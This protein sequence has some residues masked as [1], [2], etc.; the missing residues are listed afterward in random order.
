MVTAYEERAYPVLLSFR[1]RVHLAEGKFCCAEEAIRTDTDWSRRAPRVQDAKLTSE[2]NQNT[3]YAIDLDKM[4]RMLT[5]RF[6]F[7]ANVS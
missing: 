2:G 6:G 7:P 5:T 1:S 3:V 4:Q